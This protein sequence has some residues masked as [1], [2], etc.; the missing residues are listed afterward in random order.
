L[1]WT[2]SKDRHDKGNYMAHE[3]EPLLANPPT[4]EAAHHV[5]DYERFTRLL[6]WSALTCLVI[7]F[8]VVLIIS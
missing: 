1:L 4:A 5:R 6:K 7:A 2:P 3:Q 8:L